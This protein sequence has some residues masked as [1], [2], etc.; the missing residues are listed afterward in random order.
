MPDV[1]VWPLSLVNSSPRWMKTDENRLVVEPNPSEKIR[2][3]SLGMIENSQCPWTKS[4]EKNMFQTTHKPGFCYATDTIRGEPWTVAHRSQPKKVASRNLDET[5]FVY[6]EVSINGGY[7]KSS[8]CWSGFPEQKN[9]PFW[10]IPIYGNPMFNG[11]LTST[12]KGLKGI[13]TITFRGFM[14]NISEKQIEP[15]W[16]HTLGRFPAMKLPLVFIHFFSDFPAIGGTPVAMETPVS[17]NKTNM[18]YQMVR[19][20]E[21]TLWNK[22]S[23][24]MSQ[25]LILGRHRWALTQY[26]C[27]HETFTKKNEN[28]SSSGWNRLSNFR[29]NSQWHSI[30]RGFHRLNPSKY[31]IHVN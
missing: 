10:G 16:E 17:T 11:M 13:F 27:S 12:Y 26:V 29:P 15:W 25:R 20:K 1:V 30:F 21:V 2:G 28:H 23:P 19:P 18:A 3:K 24:V 9:Q 22:D 8:I 5:W 6:L 31:P 4:M 7:P 14:G